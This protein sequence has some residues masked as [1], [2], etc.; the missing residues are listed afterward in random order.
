MTG[1]LTMVV[2]SI[3]YLVISAY[4]VYLHDTPGWSFESRCS[5]ELA[6]MAFELLHFAA[7]SPGDTHRL[8]LMNPNTYSRLDDGSNDQRR[9]NVKLLHCSKAFG[10]LGARQRSL[11]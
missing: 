6:D 3:L 10:R 11:P 4:S 7:I 5:I 9:S 8:S 2:L 1:R